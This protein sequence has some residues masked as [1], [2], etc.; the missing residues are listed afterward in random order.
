VAGA[1]LGPAWPIEGWCGQG[2]RVDKNV[3]ARGGG[4]LITMEEAKHQYREIKAYR[5]V[6]CF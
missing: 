5:R 4:A 3:C 1:E 6:K 2:P